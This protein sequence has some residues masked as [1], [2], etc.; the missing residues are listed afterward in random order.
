MIGTT[1]SEP[2]KMSLKVD[3]NE[4]SEGSRRAQLLSYRLALWRSK[5]I[6]NLNVLFLCKQSISIS[7]CYSLIDRRLHC[8]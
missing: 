5:V 4:N 1:G 2:Q 8:N 3:G 7:A 6:F